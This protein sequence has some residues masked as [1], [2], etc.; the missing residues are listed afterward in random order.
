MKQLLLF[1]ATFF[2]MILIAQVGINT[3]SPKATLDVVANADGLYDKPIFKIK[4]A[5]KV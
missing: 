2:G 1:I 3:P 4:M 5:K